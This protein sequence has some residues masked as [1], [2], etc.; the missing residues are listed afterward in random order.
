MFT[1][2]LVKV[3]IYLRLTNKQGKNKMSRKQ[4]MINVLTNGEVEMEV[5]MDTLGISRKNVASL[6]TYLRKDGYNIKVT[7]RQGQSF[8][9]LTM[10]QA[11]AIVNLIDN[12]KNFGVEIECY[13]VNRISLCNEMTRRGLFVQIQGYNHNTTSYWKIVSDGSI[14]GTNGCEVVSPIL[15]G[16]NG[17]D[18]I[19]IVCE[20]LEV[21]NAKVNKSCGVH[22]HH[23]A[24]DITPRQMKNL[25][26]FYARHENTI[27]SFMPQSRRGDDN[28]YCRSTKTTIE[29]LR[30][31]NFNGVSR[32]SKLNLKSFY[33]QGT[34]E[35]RHHSATIE[36]SKITNWVLL[37]AQILVVGKNESDNS[38]R[39]AN[40]EVMIQKLSL[41][42]TEVL[43]F[44][45][46][47]EL[48]LNRVYR[49]VA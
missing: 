19:K 11:N 38:T 21:V 4:Q 45:N 5:V 22:V 36:A 15:N 8:V 39:T 9:N 20:C 29:T 3:I 32:Y 42:N 34:I 28:H 10:A 27:D 40:K 46:D 12:V 44:Y 7:R 31:L 23:E 6:L 1:K 47:R 16:Q 41:E 24:S 14:R 13:N 43:D 48:E 30:G 17:L 35:F 37:T 18:Q 33:R 26:Y 2:S 49:R 25:L